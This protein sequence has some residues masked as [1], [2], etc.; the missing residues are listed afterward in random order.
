MGA[1]LVVG[2]LN[3]L[4]VAVS[5]IITASIIGF[6]VGVGRLSHNWLI[7]KICTVYVE[8]FRNIPPLLVIFFWYFGVLSVLPQP[9]ES[10]QSDC[11]SVARLLS[12]GLSQQ[13]RLLLAEPIWGEGSW[14]I[15]AGLVVGIALTVFV[16]RRAKIGRWRPASSSRYSGPALA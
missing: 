6:L 4:L 9:R 8:I 12:F 10:I 5:G 16:A 11:R 3:T 13:S 1:R 7:R 14:L 2:F 15:L